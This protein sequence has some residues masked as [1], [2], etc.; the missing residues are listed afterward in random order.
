MIG[1]HSHSLKAATVRNCCVCGWEIWKIY[2]NVSAAAAARDT[3][4]R[5]VA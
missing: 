1:G 2:A 4:V 5:I 3:K